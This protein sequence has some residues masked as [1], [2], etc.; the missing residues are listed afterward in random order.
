M[1]TNLRQRTPMYT[2]VCQY[3]NM[4][5][6][7]LSERNGE[8]TYANALAK[9]SISPICQYAYQSRDLIVEDLHF[10]EHDVGVRLPEPSEL[11]AASK[12]VVAINNAIPTEPVVVLIEHRLPQTLEFFL[13]LAH[14][15]DA[16]QVFDDDIGNGTLAVKDG[17]LTITPDGGL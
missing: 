7:W 15:L 6:H 3:A 9:I 12:H 16:E 5:I 11:R 2:N 17:A 8:P 14:L 10:A 13:V 1:F 4:P